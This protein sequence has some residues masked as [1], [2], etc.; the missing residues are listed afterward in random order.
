MTSSYILID[1]Y[2]RTLFLIVKPVKLPF[3]VFVYFS[4]C[5]YF[6]NVEEKVKMLYEN[7][8]EICIS[9]FSMDTLIKIAHIISQYKYIILKL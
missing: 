1:I 9:T 7:M 2:H 3:C 8:L 6:D 5:Y 4:F